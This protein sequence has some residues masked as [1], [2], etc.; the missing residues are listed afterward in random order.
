[1]TMATWV[2]GMSILLVALMCATRITLEARRERRRER[3]YDGW[4][5]MSSELPTGSL[6]TTI[7][8]D[9]RTQVEI[10]QPQ[11]FSRKKTRV[12]SGRR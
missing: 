10:G 11:R 7:E 2:A 4:A 5:K 8:V 1:M 9:G 3:R 12:N 6:L